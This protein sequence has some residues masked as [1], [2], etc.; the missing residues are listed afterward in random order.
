[1]NSPPLVPAGVDLR[2]FTYMPLDVMRLRDSNISLVTS[3][4][5]FRAAIL[6][7][8]A[9]W[10]Q[11]PAASLPDD[12]RM[13]AHLAG[14]GRDMAAW[15]EVR[16]EARYG[17]VTCDDGRLYHPVIA[18]KALEAWKQKQQR[19]AQTAA[20][21][22]VRAAKNTPQPIDTKGAERNV[23]RNVERN[24]ERNVHQGNIREGN[25]IEQNPLTSFGGEEEQAEA[26][27]QAAAAP[28]QPDRKFLFK[29]TIASDEEPNFEQITAAAK[30]GLRGPPLA[31]EWQ[32]FRDHYRKTGAAFA[33]WNAAWSSWLAKLPE[34][35]AKAAIRPLGRVQANFEALQRIQGRQHEPV[36][37]GNPTFTGPTLEASANG[38]E[39]L[40]D[41]GLLPQQ[42]GNNRDLDPLRAW[43]A[44][45]NGG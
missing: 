13:L 7:W 44:R 12:D 4:E 15:G 37:D 34:F 1:M 24:D 33:D 14:F 10:H 43:R 23:E 25:R 26:Q 30:I 11:V 27:P 29:T 17:F 3:G 35:A 2:D 32:R 40:P 18:E 19:R 39:V 5:G 28:P 21:T 8:C 6:L 41:P 16:D 31:V 22:A 36:F 45:T 38:P 9:A 20:A 42:A